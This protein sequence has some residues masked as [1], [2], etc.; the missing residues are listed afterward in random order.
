MTAIVTSKF[1]TLNAENFKADIADAGT[2]VY[3][4]IGKSDVWSL[5]T[6]DT[7]DTTPFT[8][9][10]TL[11]QLGEAHQNVFAYKLLG[12][13][14]A[15]HVVPRHT[16][17]S[18]RTY[19][20]WDS[21]DPDIFD[22]SFYVITSEFK[23]YKCIKAGA[24]GSTQEP[25]QTLTVPTAESDGYIWKY[26]YT[27]SV[28]D[29]EKFLTT[30]Y[31]PV[32]T[33]SLA[34]ANDAAAEAA[35]SEADYAQY[36]NQKASRDH[37]NAGGIERIE[38]IAGGTGY[39]SDP[40]VYITGNGASA[41]ATATRTGQAVSSITVSNK[42]TDY[43]VAD[44]RISG[45]GGSDAS[46]RA[47]ISPASGHGVDPVKELGGFFVAVNTLL[48][49]T[50]GGDLTVG[51][52]FR[53]VTL[54]KNPTNFGTTTIATAT[55]LNATGAL[56]FASKTGTFQVDELITQGSGASLV[57]AYIVSIDSGTGEVYYNQNS[58]TGYGTF[59]HG[60]GNTV[61]GQTSG[62]QGTPKASASD[63][64]H[65]AEVEK[66]SGQILF[67]ENRNPIN[68]T[69]TQIEDIKVIIEF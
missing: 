50:G 44:V 49:G 20:E 25:T 26:M 4:G 35:L 15:S 66:E 67:M 13:N 24:S 9:A 1:R 40:T 52:D 59:A 68:R 16:W 10:D 7:T 17:T 5:T 46:V 12:A 48:E 62:A 21:N 32:K 38:V 14:D 60:S 51:N 18:G 22:K 54:V 36:L 39:T 30:S 53:Q 2:S 8:P 34:Y 41:A 3:V 64:L 23:V 33:V 57:Q 58:K 6:S 19:V 28:A 61:T 55:T 47:V 37:A 27:V 29:A 43:T 11:D 65:N 42:G 69:A 63:F 45:G 31:M 56:D